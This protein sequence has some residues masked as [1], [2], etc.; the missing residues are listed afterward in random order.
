[1]DLI[2]RI[3]DKKKEV[4]NTYETIL[5]IVQDLIIYHKLSKVD[6][7]KDIENP[8]VKTKCP[9]LYK[10]THENG[11]E[12]YLFSLIAPVII[13]LTGYT[14]EMIQ[15]VATTQIDDILNKSYKIGFQSRDSIIKPTVPYMVLTEDRENI[16]EVLV[17]SIE[18]NIIKCQRGSY[19]E[20]GFEV[21]ETKPFRMTKNQHTI[22]IQSYSFLGNNDYSFGYIDKKP[23]KIENNK[24]YVGSES[25]TV[26]KNQLALCTTIDEV[27]EYLLDIIGDN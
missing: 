2:Q 27:A 18:D 9:T 3:I 1:M 12:S 22:I 19:I 5:A 21:R 16:I 26:D 7:F 15:L 6:K 23:I 14:Y 8:I 20:N 24:L 4:N 11:F 25:Y 17:I 10:V 13:E